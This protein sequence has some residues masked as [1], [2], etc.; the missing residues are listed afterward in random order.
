MRTK[1]DAGLQRPLHEPATMVRS[2][3]HPPSIHIPPTPMGT[4]EKEMNMKNEILLCLHYSVLES[5]LLKV[6]GM[7]ACCACLMAEM[8]MAL[9]G[10]LSACGIVL[11]MPSISLVNARPMYAS[12][13]LPSRM[14][15]FFLFP[16]PVPQNSLILLSHQGKKSIQ[17]FR[18]GDLFFEERRLLTSSS[19]LLKPR[20]FHTVC[21]EEES[22]ERLPIV[23]IHKPKVC[24]CRQVGACLGLPIY[25]PKA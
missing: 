14:P 15:L 19:G 3:T 6:K 12:P 13:F 10:R 2:F 18:L 7:L 8:L 17:G 23:Y 9:V 22:G 25:T 4:D 1:S 24:P 21:S 20:K 11:A 16:L 5:V